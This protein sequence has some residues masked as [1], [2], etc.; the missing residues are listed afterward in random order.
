MKEID[1]PLTVKG[2][3]LSDKDWDTAEALA[4][5]L[6]GKGKGAGIRAALHAAVDQLLLGSIEDDGPYGTAVCPSP[7]RDHVFVSDDPG[8][9]QPGQW[10]TCAEYVTDSM[11]CGFGFVWHGHDIFLKHLRAVEN[12]RKAGDR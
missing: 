6:G 9:L 12:Q 11:Q 1:K 2:V 7:G 3:R 5:T 8:E 4:L 10:V